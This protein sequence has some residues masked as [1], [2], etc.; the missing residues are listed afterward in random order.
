MHIRAHAADHDLFARRVAKSEDALLFI[1]RNLYTVSAAGL[2][3]KEADNAFCVQ[4]DFVSVAFGK[5]VI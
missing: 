5:A 2:F 1:E 3:R 4:G